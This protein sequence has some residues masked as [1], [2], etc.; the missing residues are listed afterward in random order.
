MKKRILILSSIYLTILINW[1]NFEFHEKKIIDED[2]GSKSFVINLSG[3]GDG[4]SLIENDLLPTENSI[5]NV[6]HNNNFE[7]NSLGDYK[8]EEWRKDWNNNGNPWTSLNNLKIVEMEGRKSLRHNYLKDKF[9]A[10]GGGANFN[11]IIPNNQG[12]VEVYFS[13]RLFIEMG[14]DW[15]L[16]SKMSGVRNTP[17]PSGGTG[18]LY[19]NTDGFSSRLMSNKD[20]TVRFYNYH[21]SMSQLYGDNMG[22]KNWGQLKT[23]QW[24]TIT[25]RFV[26][27]KIGVSNGIIQCWIDGVLVATASNVEFRTANSPQ[28]ITEIYMNTFMGGNDIAWAPNRNQFILTDD[29]YTWSFTQEYLASNPNVKRGVNQIWSTGDKLITPLDEITENKKFSLKIIPNPSDGGK[30]T[31]KIIDN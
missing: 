11:G 12:L 9:G 3:L 25:L 15:G 26:M 6:L 7:D 24:Q 29:F 23:G 30:T 22:L 10:S 20:G 18:L 17:G 31:I 1:S 2:K 21:H 4:D 5:H 13:Y 14:F 19:K 27:N 8:L 28:N 16:G